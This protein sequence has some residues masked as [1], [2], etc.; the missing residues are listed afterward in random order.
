RYKQI[1]EG[2]T[3]ALHND[4]LHNLYR[5]GEWMPFSAANETFEGCIKGVNPVGMLEI[6]NRDGRVRT[7]GFKEVEFVK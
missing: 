6:L 7:F 4:Y 5:L 2:N 1:V 3:A